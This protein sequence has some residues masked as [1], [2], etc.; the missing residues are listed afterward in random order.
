MYVSF[1]PSVQVQFSVRYPLSVKSELVLSSVEITR[2]LGILRVKIKFILSLLIRHR[3]KAAPGIF[4]PCSWPKV[5]VI[6]GIL[7]L[8]LE[9]WEEREGRDK[10]FITSMF[11][12]Q[13]RKENQA[14]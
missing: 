6:E 2:Y 8:K 5:A 10:T 14:K 13:D 1:C 11:F 9:V 3:K 12:I 4:F 7:Y